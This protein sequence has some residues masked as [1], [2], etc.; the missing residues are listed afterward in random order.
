MQQ[1]PF[2]AKKSC[3]FPHQKRSK[4]TNRVPLRRKLFRFYP[5]CPTCVPLS[6]RVR[7]IKKKR[8][9]KPPKNIF[10]RGQQRSTKEKVWKGYIGVFNHLGTFLRIKRK[11]KYTLLQ[12]PMERLHKQKEKYSFFFIKNKPE[13]DKKNLAWNEEPS[14]RKKQFPTE[15][16]RFFWS[17]SWPKSPRCKSQLC[18]LA[19]PCQEYL[20]DSP[21]LSSKFS[22]VF[23]GQTRHH[24]ALWSFGEG[25]KECHL[26]L[27]TLIKLF[28][29]GHSQLHFFQTP[30]RKQLS[31]GGKKKSSEQKA[32]WQND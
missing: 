6:P 25:D 30:Q 18:F 16:T 1:W 32:G 20:E 29:I 9:K 22:G 3:N 11:N 26:P 5:G 28:P 21:G 27:S 4:F 7:V 10:S 8:N 15:K 19:Q 23:W 2:N 13:N 17:F 14:I 24:V 12:K 31:T